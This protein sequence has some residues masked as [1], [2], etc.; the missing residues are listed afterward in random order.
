[1]NAA[2]AVGTAGPRPGC[3][4]LVQPLRGGRPALG[5]GGAGID[6]DGGAA[7]AVLPAA[8]ARAVPAGAEQHPVVVPHVFAL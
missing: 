6:V 1:M 7:A 4:V 8:A 2:E 3:H 5:L